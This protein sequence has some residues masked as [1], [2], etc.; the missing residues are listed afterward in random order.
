[1]TVSSQE[2]QVLVESRK[3]GDREKT[4]E[5]LLGELA[6]LR[7]EYGVLQD[8]LAQAWVDAGA[9]GA[10]EA[11]LRHIV[12]SLPLPV[13]IYRRCDD[14]ILFASG[15]LEPLLGATAAALVGAKYTSFCAD[16]QAVREADELLAR[17]G[18]VHGHELRLRRQDGSLFWAAVSLRPLEYRGEEA[19]LCALVDI[20]ERIEMA[21]R[22]ERA[23]QEAESASVAK[24]TFLAHMSHEL[25]N[26]LNA[27]IGYAEMLVER[28]EELGDDEFEED[29][30]RILKVA[31]MQLSIIGDSLDLAKI[32][33]GHMSFE[34]T[35][36]RVVELMREVVT[37]ARPLVQRNANL[38]EVSLGR[39][40]GEAIGD[41]VRIRQILL[42]LLGNAAKFTHEGR[43]TLTVRRTRDD[44]DAPT[45]S[46]RVQDTGI[47][48]EPEEV[49]RLF[50]P[51]FQAR[52]GA[53]GTGLG[54]AI[55]QQL[56]RSMGGD[57]TVTSRVGAGSSFSLYLPV[58]SPEQVDEDAGRRSS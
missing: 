21:E 55:S 26:P 46:F 5:Q 44:G 8:M 33:A 6:A 42:N 56:A 2:A 35:R 17:D 36:F 28:A 41:P 29:S 40:L 57:I 15:K 54:L 53:G 32:E 14:R 47:G 52:G 38:F 49:E 45:L 24:S 3:G 7:R 13:T 20:S 16:S 9:H 43:V 30:R 10:G 50:S 51:F 39:S 25:R 27:I 58:E 31:R 19:V 48:M 4:R 12:D 23:R 11:E 22:L 1:M 34:R 37:A 18:E